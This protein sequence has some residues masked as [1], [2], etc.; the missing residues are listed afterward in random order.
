MAELER[1]A[2]PVVRADVGDFPLEMTV[3]AS[4]PGCGGWSGSLTLGNQSLC[5]GDIE[6]IYYRRPT[7]FRFPGHLSPGQQ[8]FARAEARRGLAGLLLSLPVRWL[9]HPSRIADAELKPL[10]LQ[11]AADC[12]LTVPRTILT[13]DV[14]PARQLAEGLTGPM[15]YKP[16]SA[17][18]VHVGG[19]LRLIYATQVDAT[20][21]DAE[22]TRLTAHLFQEWVAKRYDVRLTVIGHH[23]F[24]V[25]IHADSPQARRDWRSDY[26]SLRYE[27]IAIPDGTRT[28]VSD[29]LSR[30]GLPFGAFDFVVTPNGEW[31]FLEINPNGQWGWIEEHTGL[32]I[33]SAIVDHLIAGGDT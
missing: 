21:L 16:L 22:D 18:S 6:A 24:A 13:N 4:L 26:G 3:T 14:V 11:L 8:R 23:F 20:T 28:A 33:T 5:I 9:S 31:V 12:G 25:A 17:P 2:V 32:P 30:L 29:L 19:E 27:P 15:I 7:G 10:Q 1:R